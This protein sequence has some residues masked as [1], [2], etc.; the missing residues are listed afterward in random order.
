[1]I[2]YEPIL[3]SSTKSKES[4]VRADKWLKE[5]LEKHEGCKSA[6]PKSTFVPSRLIEIRGPDINNP[7]IRLQEKS[8]LPSTVSYA[9]LSHC[10]GSSMPFKL[11][12]QNLD[13]CK[14]NIPLRSLT[15]VFQDA[16]GFALHSGIL[17]IWIDSLCIIQDSSKDWAFESSTMGDI[18]HRSILNI[19]ATGFANGVNGLFVERDPNLLIP[20]ALDKDTRYKQ[21]N[22]GNYYLVDAYVWKEGI[23]ESP[24][25]KRGWVAQERALSV[26]TLHFGKEQLFWECMCRNASEVFP[27][28]IQ[29]GTMMQDPK[30]ELEELGIG[31]EVD[32]LSVRTIRGMTLEQ[33]QWLPVIEIYTQCALTFAKD[34]L[35]AISGMA[36]ELSKDMKCEYLAGLWRRDLEHQL[37]WKAK[38]AHPATR[39][40]DM[41]GPSWS[42]ASVDGRIEI[43]DWSGYFYQ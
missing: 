26:R 5:C 18:Y 25:C 42:W 8:S 3:P 33:Q 28:G 19:A 38:K 11:T 10:W 1:M 27:K 20:I 17:Y 21:A 14:G 29:R 30:R 40:E 2:H 7:G 43:P 34:K 12:L 13:E 15:K 16:I 36:R 6:F 37:L 32:R 39:K 41:R 23:D 35:V 9:T 4:I 24:L 22:K 31:L